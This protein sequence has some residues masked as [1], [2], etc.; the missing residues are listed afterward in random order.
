MI[1]V[2][3][4]RDSDRNITGLY[5]NGHSGY[6]K[7]GADIICSA[8]SVLLYTAANSL[9]S[10]CGYL[11]TAV[12][13]EDNGNGKVS[14]QIVVPADANRDRAGTAQTIMRT[15]EVGLISL[16]ASVNDNGRVYIKVT[17]EN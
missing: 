10:I 5:M 13:N 14:A 17:E 3:I 2:K 15:V 16:A 11:D 9:E 12:I 8:A 4:V 6:A 1:T 7:E